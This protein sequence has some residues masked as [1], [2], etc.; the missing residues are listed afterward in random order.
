MQSIKFRAGLIAT[1]LAG[2]AALAGHL[3]FG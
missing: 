2:L 1:S 3:R